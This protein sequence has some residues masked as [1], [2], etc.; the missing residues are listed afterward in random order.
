[1]VH[2]D[3]QYRLMFRTPIGKNIPRICSIQQ[4]GYLAAVG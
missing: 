3:G 4:Q 1:M 2:Y